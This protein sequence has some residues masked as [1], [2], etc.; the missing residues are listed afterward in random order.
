MKTLITKEKVRAR[1]G[2]TSTRRTFL[3]IPDSPAKAGPSSLTFSDTTQ[4]KHPSTAYSPEGILKSWVT[5]EHRRIAAGTVIEWKDG[6]TGSLRDAIVLSPN[7]KFQP[8]LGFGG[9]L[10]DTT[11]FMFNQLSPAA[12]A[13]LFHTLFD[14][15]EMALNVCR[16]CMGSADCATKVYSYDDGEIDPDLSRF[17]IHHDL[18]YIL[19]VLRQARG[20][21]PDLFLFASPWSPPGWMKSNGSMLGGCMR[22]TYMPS[23]ANYFLKFLRAYDAEGVPI[24]AVTI[25]NEVDADQD[26]SMPACAWPQDYEA[27]FLTMHLGPLFD[28]AGVKAKIWIIDHNYN[29]WGRAMGELETPDVM[30]YTNAIAWHGYVGEPEWINRVQNAY[31]GVE[32][33]WTEGGPDYKA[34]DYLVEWVNWGKTF[35]RVLR[36]CCRSITAWNLATDEHGRPYVGGDPTGVGGAMII[37]SQTKRIS[38]SGMFWAL[39]HF[40]RFVRRG[41]TRVDSQCTSN[42]L[43]HCAFQNPDGS[44][45]I[46]ITNPG[47]LQACTLRLSNKVAELALP[48]NSMTTLVSL[49]QSNE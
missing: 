47:S 49:P 29:L 45:V 36:N 35:S 5:D 26:G 6:Q 9:A 34:P 10:T 23:Y 25:Q 21:N 43:F 24:Q 44:L 31:P 13:G 37:D 48:A 1:V 16:I 12:R 8:I 15:S 38:Y 46:V 28:R 30:K 27:D 20:I 40:S 2:T 41:A 11:C 42:A 39:G 7:K 32:M 22:H 18:E 19:P 14:P 33:Y 4:T 3:G 17:S